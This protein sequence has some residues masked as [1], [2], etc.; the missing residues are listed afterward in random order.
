MRHLGFFADLYG[1]LINQLE[2]CQVYSLQSQRISSSACG[3][4]SPEAGCL[5]AT[6][7]LIP[8]GS[9]LARQHFAAARLQQ[10]LR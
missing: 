1:D 2:G 3:R 8:G 6:P 5:T 7:E 4:Q 9:T 10:R